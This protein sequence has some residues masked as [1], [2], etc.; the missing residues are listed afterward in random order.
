MKFIFRWLGNA[1]Y[2]FRLEKNILLVDPFLTRPRQEQIFFGRAGVDNEAI[3]AHVKECDHI[4]VS[5]AHFDHFMDVP[6]IAACTGAIMHGSANTCVL[7]QK[8]GIPEAQFHRIYAGDEFEIDGIK[9]KAIP[10]QHPWIPGYT[11][12]QIRKDLKI[13][14][15]LRDYRMDSCLSFLISIRGMRILVW[16]STGTDYA[17][18]ADVLIC[19]AV[20][21]ELWYARMMESV[22]PRLVIPSHW[23]DMFRPLS[24]STRPYF[25]PP[26]PVL[27][28]IKR[29]DLG[30]FEHKVKKAKPDCEVLVPERFKEYLV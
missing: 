18:E 30:E 7:A 12:G 17:E 14:P 8:L 4:L 29:I 22:K 25:S 1:G 9:V 6:E 11:C 23:D 20:S 21:D 10:A 27:P 15:R 26:R 16:S 2:E 5:H 13:P 3:G 28:P 19:R 24:E